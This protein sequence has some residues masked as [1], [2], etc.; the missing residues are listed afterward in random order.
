MLLCEL[1]GALSLALP[2]EVEL[3]LQL[4]GRIDMGLGLAIDQIP[5]KSLQLLLADLFDNLLLKKTRQVGGLLAFNCRQCWVVL[6]QSGGLQGVYTKPAHVGS[7]VVFLS[8]VFDETPAELATGN[9]K[10]C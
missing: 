9:P 1:I 10:S 6:I 7:L 4:L 5:I 8:P 2:H 3:L